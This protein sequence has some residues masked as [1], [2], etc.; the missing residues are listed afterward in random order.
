VLNAAGRGFLNGAFWRNM[1]HV[2]APFG[3][4]DRSLWAKGSSFAVKGLPF[5][6]MLPSCRLASSRSSCVPS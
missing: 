1:S 6:G 3:L 2:G 4:M 5:A